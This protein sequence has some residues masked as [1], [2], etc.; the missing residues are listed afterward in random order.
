MT[1]IKCLIPRT[2]VIKQGSVPKLKKPGQLTWTMQ[3]VDKNTEYLWLRIGHAG[4]INS[5]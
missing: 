4:K 2:L 1:G 5:H 3:T